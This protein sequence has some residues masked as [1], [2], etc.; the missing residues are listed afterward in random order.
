MARALGNTRGTPADRD[1][2]NRLRGR[3]GRY[4]PARSAYPRH[5]QILRRTRS[6]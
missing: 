6:T 5:H 2:D 1:V 3:R 4:S